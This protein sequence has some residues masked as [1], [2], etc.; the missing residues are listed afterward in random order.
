MRADCTSADSPL[1]GAWTVRTRTREHVW[2]W[3]KLDVLGDSPAQVG[4][5]SAALTQNVPERVFSLVGA[6][7]CAADGPLLGCG[8]SIG[9]FDNLY[10]RHCCLWWISRMN[11]GRSSPGVRTIRR[12]ISKLYQRRNVRLWWCGTLNCGWSAPGAR[13]V[14]QGCNG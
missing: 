2:L 5:R 11:G 13:T 7:I 14:R 8:R 12:L 10:Q 9:Y 3:W 6:M 4:G 1:P